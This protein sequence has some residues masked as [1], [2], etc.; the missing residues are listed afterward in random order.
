MI[1]WVLRDRSGPN[2]KSYLEAVEKFVE[3]DEVSMEARNFREHK[4]LMHIFGLMLTHKFH[5]RKSCLFEVPEAHVC[6]YCTHIDNPVSTGVI[7]PLPIPSQLHPPLPTLLS[8][9]TLH[10]SA[11]LNTSVNLCLSLPTTPL[12]S[13]SGN[14]TDSKACKSLTTV[15]ETSMSAKS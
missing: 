1:E 6:T 5:L 9:S 8:S 12:S 13:P 2:T 10:P 4:D 7:L 3:L 15:Y 14:R 11:Q